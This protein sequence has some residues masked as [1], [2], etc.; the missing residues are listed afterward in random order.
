MRHTRLEAKEF[1]RP[2]ASRL[3]GS[4]H[5]AHTDASLVS[6]TFDDGPDE[7]ETP[8]VL[9]ALADHG[10]QATFFILGE[11]ARRYP[12]LVRAIRAAGHEIGSHSDV[13][14]RLTDLPLRRV[15]AEIHRSK[16]DLEAILGDPVSLFRPPFGF[17]TRGGYLVARSLSLDV[18]GW[19]AE[20]RDWLELPVDELV[21]NALH[22]LRPGGILLLHDG[23]ELPQVKD[24][25][26]VPTFNRELLVRTLLDDIAS[27]GW[28]SVTVGTLLA[29]GRVDRRLWFRLPG[30]SP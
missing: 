10:A 2:L 14:H 16:R 11:K 20:A 3:M 13:H 23:L 9:D 19:S 30:P 27:R 7:Q 12:E 4:V 22:D 17:L 21:G 8:K 15:A 24:P 29:G 25:P 28:K 5:G 6:F 26:P 1:V 18:V